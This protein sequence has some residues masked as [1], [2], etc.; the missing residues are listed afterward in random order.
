VAVGSANKFAVALLDYLEE[1]QKAGAGGLE[2]AAMYNL[3]TA[4]D[5]AEPN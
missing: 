1:A 4:S 5:P 2:F 3:A